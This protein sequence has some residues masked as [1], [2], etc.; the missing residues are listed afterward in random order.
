[1]IL[2]DEYEIGYFRQ[3]FSESE[4]KKEERVEI[5]DHFLKELAI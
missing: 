3:G 1:M 2:T 4:S 5:R